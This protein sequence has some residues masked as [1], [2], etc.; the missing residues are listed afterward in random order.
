[1]SKKLKI[2]SLISVFL[3]TISTGKATVIVADDGWHFFQFPGWLN[4]ALPNDYSWFTSFEFTLVQ[5]ALLTVQDLGDSVDQFSVYDHGSLIFTT[6]E[7]SGGGVGN[8]FDPDL[9]ASITELSRGH[10]L[11]MP[12]DHVI[13]GVNIRYL[14]TD[15]GGGAALRLDTMSISEPNI[16]SLLILSLLLWTAVNFYPSKLRP[17]N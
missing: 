1:M 10:F 16:M 2:F 3:L 17:I 9:A 13:T 8:F 11:L 5:P 14:S 15:Y 12:G 7:P 6:S 4:P